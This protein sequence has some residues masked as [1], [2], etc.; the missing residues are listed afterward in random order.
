ME[1]TLLK[2][3][4]PLKNKLLIAVK[5]SDLFSLEPLFKMMDSKSMKELK[6]D[7]KNARMV[8]LMPWLLE[9]LLFLILI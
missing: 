6:K 1:I 7:G 5:N 8:M 4:H 3:K 2:E 9:E